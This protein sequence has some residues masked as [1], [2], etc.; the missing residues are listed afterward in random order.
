M[1][2]KSQKEILKSRKKPS[3]KEIY[4][5]LSKIKKPV[6]LLVLNNIG[7]LRARILHPDGKC[8]YNTYYDTDDRFDISC[9]WNGGTLHQ[10]L[11]SMKNFDSGYFNRQ[12]IGIIELE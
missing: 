6:F 1:K 4:E 8:F 9:F 3:Q 10:T 11:K 12:I 7:K 5:Q 2:T